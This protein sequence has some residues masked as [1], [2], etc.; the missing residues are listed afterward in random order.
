MN[1]RRLN[2]S[3]G[4]LCDHALSQS[5]LTQKTLEGFLRWSRSSDRAHTGQPGQ[6][7]CGAQQHWLLV[8]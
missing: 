3:N 7:R 8:L 4:T 5:A 6:S 1:M 2:Q